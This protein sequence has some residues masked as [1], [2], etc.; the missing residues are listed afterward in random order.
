M[1]TAEN[2]NFAGIIGHSRQIQYLE[3]II[4]TGVPA[5]AYFFSGPVKVGKFTVAKRF[6]SALS[7][8]NE[9]YLTASPDIAIV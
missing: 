4:Q 6:I 1:K 3:K 2:I 8:V 9:E 5:H 7:G